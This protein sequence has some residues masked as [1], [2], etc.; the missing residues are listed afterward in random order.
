MAGINASLFIKGEEPFILKRDEAYIGVMIDDL[1]TKGTKEPYR[2]LSSRA[3]YRLLLRSD[4]ADMRLT[5]YGYKYGLISQKRYDEFNKKRNAINEI[6]KV[7]DTKHFGETSPINDYLMSLGYERLTSGVK[8]KD[9]LKRNGVSYKLLKNYLD[10]D[11]N[12]DL[13]LLGEFELEV[14]VKYEGYIESEKK[15]AEKFRKLENIKLRQDIDYL[16]M[17]GLRIE[18]RQKLDKVRPSTIGQAGRISGVNP[19]DISILVMNLRKL[20]EI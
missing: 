14:A 2:L 20:K 16:N 13:D 11:P 15:D 10:I 3:E 9:I 17:D 1:I 19:A 18:A 6:Y 4:N 12:L 7:L 5:D 8:A